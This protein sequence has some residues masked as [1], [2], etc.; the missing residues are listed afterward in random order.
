MDK[1]TCSL[2]GC[3]GPVRTRGLCHKDYERIRN[4]GQWCPI[5][6][7]RVLAADLSW[8][9]IGDIEAGDRL[10]AFDEHA[11]HGSQRHFRNYQL[12]EVVAAESA[13]AEVVRIV[14]DDAPDLLVTPDHPLLVCRNLN[15]PPF[16]LRWAPAGDLD[17]GGL[18]PRYLE[19]VQAIQTHEA[20]YLAGLFDGEGTITSTGQGASFSQVPGAVLDYGK[21]LLQGFGFSVTEKSN[22]NGRAIETMVVSITGGL[23]ESVKFLS[24]IRPR[25]LLAKVEPDSFGLFRA[26]TKHR[27]AAVEPAGRREIRRVQT[28]TSTYLLEGMASNVSGRNDDSFPGYP[29]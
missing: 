25:R 9:P 27:V 23:A 6:D 8:K 19:P 11:V 26:V 28:T 21:S 13:V 5:P 10:V 7:H 16:M 2:E 12:T 24:M 22:C 20:G 29:L 15:G 4:R 1:G 14:F 18:L 3:E 17:L